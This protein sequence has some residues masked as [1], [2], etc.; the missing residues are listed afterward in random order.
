MATQSIWP[1]EYQH[2]RD[3]LTQMIDHPPRYEDS[4]N[5]DLLTLVAHVFP[6]AHPACFIW[7]PQYNLRLPVN[8]SIRRITSTDSC[9][10]TVRGRDGRGPEPARLKPDFVIAQGPRGNQRI[11]AIVEIKRGQE[12]NQGDADRFLAYCTR[13]SRSCNPEVT[14]RTTALLIAGGIAYEWSRDEIDLLAEDGVFKNDDLEVMRNEGRSVRV[15][16]DEFL[17]LLEGIRERC[18]NP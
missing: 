18:N 11:V 5:S 3:H 1:V 2:T 7:K 14:E 15:N 17:H 4:W 13:L 12:I 9:G 10:Q 6:A 8:P 16:T